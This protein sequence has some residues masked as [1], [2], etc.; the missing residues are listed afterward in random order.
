MSNKKITIWYLAVQNLKK[1]KQQALAIVAIIA[2]FAATIFGGGI[3]LLSLQQGVSTTEKRLGADIIVIPKEAKETLENVLVDGCTGYF[4][5]DRENV[6]EME[7]VDGI[8][9]KTEQFYFASAGSACCDVP[10]EIIGFDPDTDFV[11]RPWI[12]KKIKTQREKVIVAGSKISLGNKNTIRLYDHEYEVTAQMDQ[13]GTNMDQTIFVSMD[14]MMDIRQNAKDLGFQFLS[15]EEQE[16]KEK[17]SAVLLMVED[18]Y[19]INQIAKEIKSK[20]KQV[21][22]VVANEIV[23]SVSERL[24]I[25]ASIYPFFLVALMSVLFLALFVIYGMVIK[26]RKKELSLLRMIGMKKRKII[27]MLLCEVVILS[28]VA[29]LIGNGIVAIALFPFEIYIGDVL[30]TPYI[31]PESVEIVKLIIA[32]GA[33]VFLANIVA[34]LITTRSVYKKEVYQNMR[35][36]A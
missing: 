30:G 8:A 23:A 20:N 28:I 4:Y 32:N 26:L 11:V 31:R 5:M 7:Q 25:L 3:L 6:K 35:E 24:T 18:G 17:L 9:E 15:G 12:Q 13:T 33:I 19:D 29:L 21:D 27:E 10:V 16:I 22:V 34:I 36:G 14:M 1:K 2:I